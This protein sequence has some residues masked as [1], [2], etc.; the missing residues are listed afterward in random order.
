VSGAGASEANRTISH[1]D[2]FP[3]NQVRSPCVCGWPV[4]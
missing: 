2:W 4:Q 1:L 3:M